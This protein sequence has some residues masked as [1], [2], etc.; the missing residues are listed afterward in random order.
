MRLQR[1]SAQANRSAVI[2][3]A[4]TQKLS[5]KQAARLEK[6]KKL[7]EMLRTKAQAEEEGREEDVE[8]SKNWSYSIE[9]NDAWEK[10]LKRKKTR[11]DF[12]YHG[13]LLNTCVSRF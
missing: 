3:E 1:E 4:T 5:V 10:R 13:M 8:R 12:E 11:A 9:E 6:Q 2:T 7:A